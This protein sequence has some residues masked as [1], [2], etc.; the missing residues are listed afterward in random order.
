MYVKKC[1]S[2]IRCWDSNS[3]PLEHEPPPITTRPGLPPGTSIFVPP[4]SPGCVPK[5]TKNQLNLSEVF[6]PILSSIFDL[7]GQFFCLS[8]RAEN[9][10]LIFTETASLKWKKSTLPSRRYLNIFKL[11]H[12][13]IESISLNVQV[14][15]SS[16]IP[17]FWSLAGLAKWL[18]A[19]CE[20]LLQINKGLKLN[21]L[22]GC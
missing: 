2:S 11:I 12:L 22:K 1:P 21:Y 13:D 17:L 15:E 7:D 20:H 19:N 6:A 14:N 3:R 5:N 8:I 16:R 9:N 10:S 18:I 4:L